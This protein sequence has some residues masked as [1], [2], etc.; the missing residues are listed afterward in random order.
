MF[1]HKHAVAGLLCLTPASLFL[2]QYLCI[3]VQE[4]TLLAQHETQRLLLVQHFGY[5][6]AAPLVQ[7]SPFTLDVST[8]GGRVL[9]LINQAAPGLL[10]PCG[11]AFLLCDYTGLFK[12]SPASPDS[13]DFKKRR[14]YLWLVPLLFALLCLTSRGPGAVVC[15]YEARLDLAMG[16]YQSALHWLDKAVALN[17]AL[18]QAA[19]YHR[20]RGYALYFLYPGQQSDDSRIYLASVYRSQGNYL[21]AYQELL[22][23]WQ[24]HQTTPWVE[25]EMD[26]TLTRLGEFVQP[27]HGPAVQ[28]S[29]NDDSSLPWLQLLSVVDPS[30]VYGQYMAGRVQCDLHN[31]AMCLTHMQMVLHLSPDADIQSSAYTYMAI[32]ASGQGNYATSRELLFKAVALDRDYHN[33]TAREELSGLH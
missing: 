9:L 22:A 23:V 15:E 2:L 18:N 11:A 14:T 3:D 28:R 12:G 31:Y 13:R 7:F 17:P 30:N 5:H 1:E 32:S 6:V 25:D 8:L 27:L 16:N 33:N 26:I 19:Y 29:E 24:Y 21:G 20:E 4:M 10:L